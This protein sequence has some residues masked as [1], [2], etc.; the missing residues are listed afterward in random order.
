MY[1][2]WGP[3]PVGVDRPCVTKAVVGNNTPITSSWGP[4]DRQKRGKHR[5]NSPPLYPW[6]QQTPGLS[7]C[8]P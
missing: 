7:S 3:N 6:A 1:S 2:V 5:K 4:W 8:L